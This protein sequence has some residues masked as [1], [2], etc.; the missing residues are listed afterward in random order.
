MSIGKKLNLIFLSII[1]LL[2]ITVGISFVN[3]NNI[4]KKMD[5]AL[6]VRV[7]TIQTIDDIRF[8]IAMQGLYA[9]EILID[10]TTENEGNFI[11]YQSYLDDK[12]IALG[13]LS[14][15]KTMKNFQAD[16]AAANERFNAIATDYLAAVDKMDYEKSESLVKNE[17][18]T[19][20]AEI[21]NISEEIL[22]FQ[23]AQLDEIVADSNKAITISKQSSAIVFIISLLIGLGLIIF[24]KR[25]VSDPLVKIVK[26]T[27]VIAEGDLIQEDIVVR[28]KDEIGQL[29]QAFNLMKGNLQNLIRSTQFNTEQL[30]ASAEQ[31]SAS[32]EEITATSEDVTGRV[33]N[34]AEVAQT[35]SSIALESA[36]AMEET[37]TGVQRIAESTQTLHASSIDASETAN[38]GGTIIGH[39]KQQMEVI[40]TSTIQVNDLVQKLSK[41]TEEIGHIT[42]VITDITDQ[43]N[44]L[45]LNAAIEAARAGEHGKGFAVVADEVR[46]L[47]EESK[48][49]ANSIVALTMEIKA[50]TKNVENAVNNS[51]VS[52]KDGV[53]IIGDAGDAFYAIEN[54]VELMTTQIQEISATSEQL[55][56]SAVEVLASVNEIA[57]GSS[58]AASNIEMIA[59]AMEEQSAT[60]EQVN[61]VALGLSDSA[62]DLQT[63]IQKFRV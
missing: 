55:S 41:Q 16:I 32:T 45:A 43:T 36:F 63:E 40:N 51:L 58:S 34:T 24:V 13:D 23:N 12:V 52:V 56:A 9:R 3:L 33:A 60:M 50:D 26:S 4:D 62:Q 42:K 22:A 7:V 35:L 53:K 57:E 30:S 17:I 15:T 18:Q 10:P 39:A 61:H 38:H 8:G 11:K 31:L 29:A 28:S 49:S 6:E 59:A 44:L 20:S 27:N 37:A 21:L 46:K 47:A 48:N 14:F 1:L 19:A 25:T 5:E 54:A 2:T